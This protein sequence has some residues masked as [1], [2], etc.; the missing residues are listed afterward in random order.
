MTQAPVSNN[1]NVFITTSRGRRLSIDTTSIESIYFMEDVFSFCMVGKMKFTDY[2]GVMELGNVWGYLDDFIT[3]IYGTSDTEFINRK[4]LLYKIDKQLPTHNELHKN[5]VFEITFVSPLYYQWHFK[6]YSRSFKE[7]KTSDIMRHI[8]KHM[9]NG[10]F[11]T[12][13]AANE[14]ITNFYTG[15]KSPAENFKYLME[16]SSGVYSKKPGYL[17]FENSEGYNLVT[18]PYLMN[19]T[20][21]VMQPNEEDNKKYWFYTTN[22]YLMNKIISFD[23]DGVDNGSIQ[24]LSGGYRMGYDIL[25]K[26]NIVNVYTYKSSRK[27]FIDNIL[28]NPEYPL[29][30]P[31]IT[32]NERFIKT[33]ES[34]EDFIDNLYYNNW[35]KQYSVQQTFSLYV[36][37]SEK[38]KAGGVIEISW[39]SINTGDTNQNFTG[40]YFV[41]SITHFFDKNS[42]PYYNQKLILMKNAYDGVNI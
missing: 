31:A 12:F 17:C 11:V 38:R 1:L 39:P 36:K 6:Q 16:R 37:G 4:F 28:G 7:M 14:R 34:R 27:K 40:K 26:K 15:L 13:E 9:V 35:L 10:E 30:D 19:K 3:I 42:S 33:G 8:M 32:G 20:V 23:R 2:G 29:L 21:E 41:K 24:Q 18:L 25:R 22:T 5:N